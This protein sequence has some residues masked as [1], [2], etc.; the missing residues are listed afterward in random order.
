[1]SSSSSLPSLSRP[2]ADRRVRRDPE[3]LIGRFEN[4]YGRNIAS[5]VGDVHR[6]RESC[7]TWVS[8]E[9]AVIEMKLLSDAKTISLVATRR[10]TVMTIRLFFFYSSRFHGR[11]VP[12]FYP[13]G[14][15]AVLGHAAQQQMADVQFG[16]RHRYRFPRI[17]VVYTVF[18]RIL[19]PV[20]PRSI[21]LFHF[22]VRAACKKQICMHVN[23]C[24]R[25][26][27]TIDWRTT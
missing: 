5:G 10:P 8:S 7:V 11:I 15:V 2:A 14:A 26:E 17:G 25:I 27:R 19:L 22:D 1:M 12:D 13:V 21:Q 16:T 9:F 4:E 24:A 3:N 6:S 23:L 18:D 20:I